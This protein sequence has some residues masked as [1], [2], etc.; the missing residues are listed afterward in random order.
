[1]T[2]EDIFGYIFLGPLAV[3]VVASVV[4]IVYTLLGMAVK[5][6]MRKTGGL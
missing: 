3:M 4:G 1:M 5:W 2:G 6:I